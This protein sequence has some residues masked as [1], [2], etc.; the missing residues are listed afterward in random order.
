[1]GDFIAIHLARFILDVVA[2]VVSFGLLGHG[3]VA[4]DEVGIQ[5]I[6]SCLSEAGDSSESGTAESDVWLHSSRVWHL[7]QA[8]FSLQSCRLR[9]FMSIP[10]HSVR[11]PPPELPPAKCQMCVSPDQ[12][13]WPTDLRP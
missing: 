6:Q 5:L 11:R 13:T 2:I 10:R 7:T 1:M 8:F 12:V 9:Q 4:H 3:V